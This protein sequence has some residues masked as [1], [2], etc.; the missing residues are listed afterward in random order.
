MTDAGGLS[1]R[2]V[3]RMGVI[4]LAEWRLAAPA[5]EGLGLGRPPRGPGTCEGFLTA[6]PLTEAANRTTWYEAR[7]LACGHEY[8]SPNGRVLP[9]SSRRF[10]MPEGLW[11]QRQTVWA[12]MFGPAKEAP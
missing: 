10:E 1:S 9:R 8:V 12:K 4:L 7:C 11:D 2:L 6:L 3:D 5:D